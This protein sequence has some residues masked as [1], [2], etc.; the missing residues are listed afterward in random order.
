MILQQGHSPTRADIERLPLLRPLISQ[1]AGEEDGSPR[2][3]GGGSAG[4]LEDFAGWSVEEHLQQR[5]VAGVQPEQAAEAL[6]ELV[7]RAAGLTRGVGIDVI[8]ALDVELAPPE[9]SQ[10]PELPTRLAE[11]EAAEGAA[12]ALGGPPRPAALLRALLGAL[13]MRGRLVANCRKVEMMPADSEHLWLKEGSLSFFNP[14]SLLLSG[15]RHGALLH[16]LAEV[17]GRVAR[18]E[19]PVAD[20]EVAQYR[21]FEQFHPAFEAVAGR[22]PRGAAGPGPQLVALVV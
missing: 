2:G 20:A 10:P 16:G 22:G 18:G 12:A 4:F 1:L 14:H 21:L 17:A 11:A 3:G 19:L 13:A 8:L 5:G 15:A 6:R 9:P 7:G